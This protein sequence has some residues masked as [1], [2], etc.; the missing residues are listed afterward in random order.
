M[1]FSSSLG[2][3]RFIAAAHEANS[4][5]VVTTPGSGLVMLATSKGVKGA[6]GKLDAADAGGASELLQL[7]VSPAQGEARRSIDKC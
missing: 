1:R 4:L 5:V 3:Q 2:A 7:A 6:F